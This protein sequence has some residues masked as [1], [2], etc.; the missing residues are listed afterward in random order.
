MADLVA[1]NTT[2]RRAEQVDTQVLL[3][4]VAMFLAAALAFTPAVFLA[5]LVAGSMT[6][7]RFAA[8]TGWPWVIGWIARMLFVLGVGPGSRRTPV[9]ISSFVW[10]YLHI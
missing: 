6:I 10:R 5:A 8:V 4:S 3:R 1:G 7:P 9:I 2:C